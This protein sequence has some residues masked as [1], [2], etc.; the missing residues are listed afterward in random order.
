L[1]SWNTAQKKSTKVNVPETKPYELRGKLNLGPLKFGAL[2]ARAQELAF[3]ARPN[4]LL[5]DSPLELQTPLGNVTVASASYKNLLNFSASEQPQIDFALSAKVDVASRLKDFG[6]SLNGL[7]NTTLS[8]PPLQCRIERVLSK[9]GERE[10]AHWDLDTTGNFRAP[11]FGGEI[12]VEG[13]NARGLFGPAPSFGGDLFLRGAEGVRFKAFTDANQQLGALISGL[14]GKALGKLALRANLAL[15]NFEA[16]DLSIAGIK[17]FDLDIESLDFKDNEFWFDGELAMTLNYP[18]VR[19][20]FPAIFSD[21][22]IKALT[23][24]IKKLA[25]KFSLSEDG[26]LTGPLAT[27]LPDNMV[28]EGYGHESGFSALLDMRL[29]QDVKAAVPPHRVPWKTIAAPFKKP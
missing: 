9:L 1:L 29:K 8:G 13:L 24:G 23:F 19:A 10:L 27:K 11:F 18:L 16:A 21:D 12:S 14:P 28:L 3:I 6:I 20:A 2:Q 5:L 17:R 15:T 25:M 26:W 4:H 7:E 22:K